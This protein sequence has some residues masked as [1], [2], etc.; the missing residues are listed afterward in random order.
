MNKKKITG[1][2]SKPRLYI[3]KSNKHIYAQLINDQTNHIIATS[4]TV[5]PEI[6]NDY[7]EFRNCN[8]AKLV[9]K[10]IASKS[11][12]KGFTQIVFDR[13]SNVYHGQIQ[14]LAESIRLEGIN[15]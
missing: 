3:F 8:K 12:A 5:S 6:R 10:D 9:G 15:F 7:K 4:S 14:V 11:K 1:T 2:P 13:G